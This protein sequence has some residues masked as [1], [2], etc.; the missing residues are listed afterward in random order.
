MQGEQLQLS[1]QGS[2]EFVH[3]TQSILS[4]LMRQM[5]INH[6][7][8]DLLMTEQFLDRVQMRS[9]FKQMCREGMPQR[10]HRSGGDV[11]LLASDNQRSLSLIVRRF[12]C[13]ASRAT[14]ISGCEV[15]RTTT[16]SRASEPG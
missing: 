12:G 10:M 3:Q 14:I 8:S 7:R 11:Q 9:G 5:Q 4:R 2:T 1:R 6:R 13:V 15:G 16:R